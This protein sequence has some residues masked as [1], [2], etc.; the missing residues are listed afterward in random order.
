MNLVE[1]FDPSPQGVSRREVLRRVA[2][3]G[4]GAALSGYPVLSTGPR[5]DSAPQPGRI[6]V[7]HHMLPPF[8]MDLRRADPNA[9]VMPTWSPSKSLDDMEKNGVT[10][11]LLSLAVSG[12]SFDAGEGGRSLARK[13]NDYGAELIKDHPASFGLLAALPMPD[14]KGSLAELE[15]ALA[16]GRNLHTGF[17]GAESPHGRGVRASECA[18]LLRQAPCPRAGLVHRIPFRYDADNRK[19]SREWNLFQISECAIYFLA[20]RRNHA[21]AGEPHRP[22]VSKGPGVADAERRALRIEAAVL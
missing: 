12:V 11:A 21:H 3:M 18:Q 16:G 9:G 1:N 17:R 2:V 13:S 10:T 19:P 5:A 6:D 8:Y 7:H 14:P 22:D 15:Y 20:W 4:A